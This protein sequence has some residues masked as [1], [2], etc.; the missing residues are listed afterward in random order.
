MG[1][2]K[3]SKNKKNKNSKGSSGIPNW[4]LSTLVI[5][6]VLAVL[7]TCVGTFIASSGIAMRWSV[8]V[9]LDDF[10]VSGN[11]MSYFYGTTYMNFISQYSSYMSY[12][13][14]DQSISPKL[15]T[16][17]ASGY[18]DAMLLQTNFEGT[19]HDYFM[20]ETVASVKNLLIYCAQA[21]KMNISLTD[22][23]L[24]D[25]EASIDQLVLEIRSAYGSTLSEETCFANVYA[26][27]V[28]RD[29]IRDAMKLS[30]LA[31]KCSDQ[32]G[33]DIEATLTDDRVNNE[34]ANNKLDYDLV[35]Y[36]SY[37]FSVYYDDVVKE[38][39]PDKKADDLTAEEKAEVLTLYKEKI[40]AVSAT[41]KEFSGNTT[42]ADFLNALVDHFVKE[43]YSDEFDTAT[44]DLTSEQKPSEDDLATIKDKM[45]AAVIAEVVKDATEVT[46]DVATHDKEDGTKS[47][48]IYDI[49]ISSEAATAFDKLKTNLFDAATDAKKDAL[50]KKANYVKAEEGKEEDKLSEWAFANGRKEN[51]STVIEEGDGANGAENTAAT[52]SFY[53]TVYLMSKPVYKDETL[54][55]DVA[56]MLFTEAAKASTAIGALKEIGATVTKED[57][58]KIANDASNPAAAASSLTDYI[59]GT[60]ESEEFDAWLFAEGLTV[61]TYTSA[62]IEM[63]DGSLMV[64]L[65]L[66]QGDIPAWENTVK[67]ALYS[68]D[69]VAKETEMNEEFGSAVVLHTDL[70]SKIGN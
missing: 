7:A 60:M 6:V 53:A 62:P 9:E 10:K 15:Q 33:K 45:I 36:Y 64:A 44:K 54:S 66:R 29:D 47:Y 58:E 35:D 70:F 23:D 30:M 8:A 12:L 18:Y 46:K 11:M 14:L 17:N 16:F 43:E 3:I 69:Y 28:S 68:D 57:F 67:N 1:K 25:V 34:Y 49:S 2:L 40:A 27:G 48:S 55:R 42:P 65:Y 37:T 39:Y 59:V 63:S 56:Y 5:I 32:I 20:E 13:S 61:G 26:S 21:K 22:E 19:W 50:V 51:D 38:K 4:L 41:A 24:A 31:S 52:E